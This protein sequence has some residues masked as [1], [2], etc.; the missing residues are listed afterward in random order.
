MILVVM[1]SMMMSSIAFFEAYKSGESNRNASVEFRLW[2]CAL[3]AT[4]YI[5]HKSAKNATA[6]IHVRR[7]PTVPK[8]SIK[9]LLFSTWESRD[10][11]LPT[12]H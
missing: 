10:P 2:T 8:V 6:R 1:G 7:C 5:L 9:Y 11:H 4:R 12:K 3:K